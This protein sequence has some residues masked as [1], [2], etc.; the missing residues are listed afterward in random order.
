MRSVAGTLAL[1]AGYLAV[2]VAMMQVRATLGLDDGG[3]ITIGILAAIPVL[4]G[5]ASAWVFLA[6]HPRSRQTLAG[7]GLHAARPSAAGLDL[8]RLLRLTL[9]GCLIGVG[10]ETTP[11]VTAVGAITGAVVALDWANARRRALLTGSATA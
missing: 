5:G 9:V 3:D 8:A 2:S 7:P 11:W 6:I 10:S 1:L 4:V